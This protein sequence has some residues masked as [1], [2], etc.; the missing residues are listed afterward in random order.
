[1]WKRRRAALALSLCLILAP[2]AGAAPQVEGSGAQDIDEAWMKAVAANDLEAVMACYSQDAVMWLPGAPEA[3]GHDAIRSSYAEL[4]EANTVTD[5]TVT[6]T[7]YETSGDLSVGWGDFALTL[8]PKAGGEPVV[9]K[10]RFTEIARGE[11][12][13]WAYIA[14]HASSPASPTAQP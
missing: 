10:G 7:H 1:M 4:F 8:S 9:L 14:D 3:R 2:L 13:K 11:D 6:N 12:G 5:V